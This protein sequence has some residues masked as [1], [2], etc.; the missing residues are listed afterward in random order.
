M[1]SQQFGLRCNHDT[2]CLCKSHIATEIMALEEREPS[3]E[4][5]LTVA[6]S[7]P[8]DDLSVKMIGPIFRRTL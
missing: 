4:I 7:G 5:P 6:T 3:H 8:S 2:K 1:Q